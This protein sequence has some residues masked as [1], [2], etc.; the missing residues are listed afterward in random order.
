LVLP[1]GSSGIGDS[2]LIPLCAFHLIVFKPIRTSPNEQSHGKANRECHNFPDTL[3]HRLRS[4]QIPSVSQ[5]RSHCNL[6]SDQLETGIIF[7]VQSVAH[8]ARLPR[9]V[10]P[11]CNDRRRTQSNHRTMNRCGNNGRIERG[12]FYKSKIYGK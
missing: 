6:L 9:P 2:N 11:S 10:K 7:G 8:Y 4:L 3:R 5:Y 12:V 1:D